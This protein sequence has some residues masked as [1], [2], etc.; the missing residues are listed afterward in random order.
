MNISRAT[1]HS[2]RSDAITEVKI[3]GVLRSEL[4]VEVLVS[5]EAPVDNPEAVLKSFQDGL[6]SDMVKL[7]IVL[8]LTFQRH[9]VVYNGQ[10]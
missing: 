4:V 3:N 8:K 7:L 9:L 6:D 1:S 10:V 2:H 5:F